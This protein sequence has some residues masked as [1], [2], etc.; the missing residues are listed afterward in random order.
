MAGARFQD[1]IARLKADY[2]R[3]KPGRQSLL[4]LIDEA[5]IA[6][7]V[8]N[9]NAIENSTLTLEDTEK[10]LFAAEVSKHMD[11][12]EVFEAQNLARVTQYISDKSR[13]LE[14]SLDLILLLHKMLMVN[15]DDS[16][17]GRIR[18]PGEYVRVGTHVAPPPEQLEETLN[19][20]I[21]SYE[22]DHHSFFLDR[23]ALFHLGFEH[24]HPFVDGN[25]R[26]GRVLMNLQLLRLG[27]PPI[28]VRNKEKHVYY[29]A[30]RAFDS[31]RKTQEMDR[32]LGLALLESLS[33]RVTYLNGMK[34]VNLTDFARDNGGSV[35]SMLNAA[36]R[37]TIRA[38]REHGHWKIGDSR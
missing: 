4:R 10:I 27:F 19:Q 37:Q 32:L 20:L 23:I 1:G 17:A 5:E 7:A 13:E 30:L 38:F 31:S 33:K 8:Y 11:V 24:A 18:S 6:E 15:I 9:S 35:T 21:V 28:I 12:R 2:E 29:S 26:I 16:I 36:R 22:S 25:G 14:L 3:L 34:I